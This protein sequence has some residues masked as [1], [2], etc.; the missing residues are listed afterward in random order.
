[1]FTDG[2]PVELGYVYTLKAL[3]LGNSK[4]VKGGSTMDKKDTI[5]NAKGIDNLEVE[6]NAREA[7]REFT[8]KTSPKSNQPEKNRW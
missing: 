5:K 7:S 6:M 1:M 2:I 8:Q 4:D 3:C